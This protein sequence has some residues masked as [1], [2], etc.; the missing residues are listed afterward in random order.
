MDS[1]HIKR[2]EKSRNLNKIYSKFQVS[3]LKRRIRQFFMIF[4]V[5]LSVEFEPIIK[6][7]EIRW[8]VSFFEPL[9][10]SECRVSD[11]RI[12]SVYRENSIIQQLH[13]QQIVGLSNNFSMDWYWSGFQKKFRMSK[14]SDYRLSDYG[15]FFVYIY[16]PTVELKLFQI[17]LEEV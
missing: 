9:W 6:K 11:Y 15:I 4:G 8:E 3:Q 10:M 5:Q 1:L 13:L 2:R 14:L 7:H 17:V 12:S 16:I